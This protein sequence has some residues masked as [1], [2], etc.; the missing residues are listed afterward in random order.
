MSDRKPT[1]RVL[2]LGGTAEARRLASDLTARGDIHVIS[3]LAGRTADPLLPAGEVRIG[4]FGGVG[5]LTT[6]LREH[7]IQAVVDATHPFARNITAAAVVATARLGLPFLVLCRPG[8]Q[9]VSGDDWH[10]VKSLDAAAQLLPTVGRRV[11]LT[12]GRKDL[13][14]FAVLDELWFLV[15]SVEAPTPPMPARC[16]TV[17]D[18]GPFTVDGELDLLRTYEIDV[19]VTKDSGSE[20]ASA[21]LTAARQLELPVVIVRRP[22]LPDVPTVSTEAEVNSWLS[23]TLRLG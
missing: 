18:R 16:E 10:W 14:V 4:G 20:M 23:T 22:P 19:L 8:W 21:K 15:R 11:F 7:S 12:T 13:A 6:W 9:P 3:S 5:G 17:L 2:V 1:A